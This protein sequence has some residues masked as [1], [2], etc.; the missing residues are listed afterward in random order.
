ME[1]KVN[2]YILY[3]V[4]KS[5]YK[6]QQLMRTLNILPVH[7]GTSFSWQRTFLS[8]SIFIS[9]KINE[10]RLLYIL[11]QREIKKKK[12]YKNKVLDRT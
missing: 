11:L 1:I 10:W 8:R 9:E 2:V 3:N 12:K 4:N 5:S 6:Y 7:T